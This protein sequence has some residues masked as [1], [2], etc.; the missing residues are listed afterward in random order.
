MY[1]HLLV[2]VDGSPSSEGGLEEA[3]KLARL[4]GGR[5]RLLHLAGLVPLSINAEG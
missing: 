2:P 5:M 4:T 3:I 1:Q